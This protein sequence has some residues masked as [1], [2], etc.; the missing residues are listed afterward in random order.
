M[1]K[2]AGLKNASEIVGGIERLVKLGYDNDIKEDFI[3]YRTDDKMGYIDVEKKKDNI[4][5]IEYIESKIKG[6]GKELIKKLIHDAKKN[7]VEIITLTTTENNLNFFNKV[8][9]IEMGDNN[10][11]NDIPMVLY[12]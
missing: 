10:D 8:G 3:K 4:W 2:S 5:H 12:M 7:G 9:F 6:G 1:I 11:P